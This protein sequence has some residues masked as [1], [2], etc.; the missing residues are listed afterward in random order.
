MRTSLNFPIIPGYTISAQISLSDRTIVYRAIEDVKQRPVIIK[1]L[2][3]TDPSPS[4]VVQFCNQYEILCHLSRAGIVSPVSLQPC[5]HTYALVMEDCGSMSLAEYQRSHPLS[6]AEI[7]DVASQLATA[8]HH[9][10]QH[11]VIHKDLKPANILIHPVTKQVQPIDF[12]IASLLPKETP[13]A[14]APKRLEGTLAY[15]APEQTGRMNRGVDYRTDFYTLGVTLFELLTGT[16][17]FS[18]NDPIESVY[19][20]LAKQPPRVEQLCPELPV[21]LSDLVGKLMAKNPE[22]RYQSA[23]GLKYDLDL[24]LTQWQAMGQIDRFEIATHDLSERFSV[25]AKLYGRER[26]VR[27][28]LAAVDRVANGSTELMLIAGCSG[29]G[30]TAIVNEI[31]QPITR[32]RG[33]FIKG[34]FDQFNRN[35]PL[36]AFVQAFRQLM[37]MLLTST[38]DRLDIWKTQILAALGEHTRVIIDVIP[39]LELIVGSQPPAPEL[40]GSAGQN[41]FNLLFQKFVGVFATPDHPLTIFIDDLQ[42]ADS[43]S[44]NL[45]QLMVSKSSTGNLLTIGAYRDNEVTAA[46]PLMLTIAEASAAGAA[47]ETI[48]LS[49][50][51]DASLHQLVSDTLMC[52][53]KLAQPMTDLVY[54]YTRGNPFFATQL[55]KT[56]H[57]DG[58]IFLDRSARCWQY[59]I[60]QINSTSLTDD[61]VELMTQQLHRLPVSTQTQ[62]QVAA[63]IGDKFD[64]QTLTIVSAQTATT[65][66]IDLLPA[67]QE[68][69][70]LPIGAADKLFQIGTGDLPDLEVDAAPAYKFLHDRVQQAA[71]ALIPAA[72]M[73]A[74]HLQIGRL[75]Q[76]AMALGERDNRVFEI[77]NHLNQGISLIV[78]ATE[79]Q[80]LAQLDLLAGQ[81]AQQAT[82]YGSALDYFTIGIDLL[83]HDCWECQYPLALAIYTGAAESA[84]LC[85]NFELMEQ[86]ARVVLD[87]ADT[88]LD[89]A[90]VYVIKIQACVARS[91]MLAAIELAREFLRNLDIYLP[92][93]STPAEIEQS[94][95]QIQSLFDNIEIESL[96]ELPITISPAQQA[97]MTILSS[98]MSAAFQVAPDLLPLL[99]FAQVDL[100]I[101][102]GN[103][104]ES[105]YGYIMYGLLLVTMLE[106]IESGY[107]FGRVGMTL[108]DRLH[109]PNLAAKTIF[110]FNTHLR[111]LKEPI[112][113]TLTGIL[114]AYTSGLEVGDLEYVA[115]SL[116]CYSYTAYHSGQELDRLRQTFDEHRN[117]LQCFRQNNYLNIQSIY[118]QSVLKLLTPSAEVDCL[119]S[120]DYDETDRIQQCL[121]A[122]QLTELHQIYCSKLMLSYLFQRYDRAV[123]HARLA[124]QYANVAKGLMI[125]QIFCFYDALTQLAIYPA[126]DRLDRAAILERVS[127]HQVQFTEWERH[128]PSNHAH[129]C[130][131]IA[132]ERCRVLGAKAEALD[133]YDRA[134]NLASANQFIHTAAIANELAAKFYLDWD[135]PKVAAGYLQAAY[136]CYFQWGAQAK[137][138]DLEQRYPHL[139]AQSRSC[140]VEFPITDR[141]IDL[142]AKLSQSFSNSTL[143]ADLDLAAILQASQSLSSTIELQDLL[144]QLTQIILHN[145]GGDLCALILPNC[146]GD[147]YLEALATSDTT[148]VRSIPLTDARQLPIKLI[149]YVKHTQ[150]VVVIDNLNTDL[151]IIDE[152]L[153][154]HQ[155]QSML[156]LPM[157]DRGVL[158]GILYLHNR[159]TSRVFTP[160]RLQVLHLLCAQA[161]ISLA[162]ARLYQQSQ[163][164]AQ[165]LAQSLV[166]LR[167]SEARFQKFAD[168]LPGVLFQTR[169]DAKNRS[170]DITYI[171]ARCSEL[172]EIGA[173]A[174]MTEGYDLRTFEHP[175][176]TDRI[177]QS[178]DRAIE[179]LMPIC[180]EFRIVTPSGKVKWVQ[181]AA[182]PEIQ[183][184]GYLTWD[185]VL[186]DISDRKATEL[187]LHQTQSQYLRLGKN[188]P[189]S[190]YQY[191][192][193][194]DGTDRFSYVSPGIRD[195]YG[196]EPEAAMQDPNALWSR[197]WPED[198]A[199]LK[200][201]IAKS[202]QTLESFTVEYRI[203]TM[204]ADLK[205][206]AAYSHP[207][208]RDNGDVV[209]DGLLLDISDR[210]QAELQLQ[211][212]NAELLRANR[213]KDEFLA[214]MSHELRTPLNAILGMSEALKEQVFGPITERQ[215]KALTTI[216]RSGS[217]LLELIN[218]ILDLAKIESGQLELDY[219]PTDINLLCKSSLTFIKQQALVKRIALTT[220]IPPDLPQLLVDERRIRQVLINLLNNAVKF[221]P[222]G[223]QVNL[224][225]SWQQQFNLDVGGA[226]PHNY[227]HIAV[228]DTGLGIAP[229]HIDRLFQ[230]FIQIDSA[231]NRQY[232]GTGLGLAL[233]KKIVELHRGRVGLTSE[234]GVGSC[235]SI[236]LPSAPIELVPIV[237]I[238]P[239]PTESILSAPL[240]IRPHSILIVE[241]NEANISTISSYLAANGYH[242][243]IA[244]NGLAAIELTQ[245][246]RPDLI[247]M[248]IQMP[249]M[250][251]IAAIHA[252][253]SNPE[254]LDISIVA[255]TALAMEGDRER[256]LAAGANEYI[257]KPIKLKQLLTTIQQLLTARS[258]D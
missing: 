90:S 19:C 30:K 84:Y 199:Q 23:L 167:A 1:L 180:E 53:P 226:L 166:A 79:R 105:T 35:I 174:M 213:L 196:C 191:I 27:S 132:A 12:G 234:L 83:E 218:D 135:K 227:I 94:L 194:P 179:H 96:L 141:S 57:Q 101:S 32:Q 148:T 239:A 20:H 237:S 131:L 158:T 124:R 126:A 68:G 170:V 11:Q 145:S 119:S 202:I 17:P 208:R 59:D 74:I 130:L 38:D 110:G 125:F 109:A 67:L 251:G 210:K 247:L 71:Y 91:Q 160:D 39:E 211:Q 117:V 100:S 108:L 186:L 181:V 255:L 228:T 185:G 93:R 80:E 173:A 215:L 10:A 118:Y 154:L 232:E 147:W 104:P 203:T 86:L 95:A 188:I 121:A 153:D 177:A 254:S 64:L 150:T 92:E 34:K 151:P 72:Q 171:S 69:L 142:H 256:C 219:Q 129:H 168:N 66:A 246:A 61:V 51:T 189:G 31:Y 157:L 107:R 128:A 224:A 133:L 58:A 16:L 49:P 103:A 14:L 26:E 85:T 252:I 18:C 182:Q 162:N 5:Q 37:G 113:N 82:A 200:E 2:R 159:S 248:D 244:T 8:L 76:Q 212:T 209:W 111:Y 230:P 33:Y 77:V 238:T 4:E 112:R 78:D 7:L 24:C 165:N 207:E 75:Q 44:L 220:T 245:S 47:I 183:A 229:E 155:P 88:W 164:S 161:A 242:L 225:V 81:K 175:D 152:Y 187:A 28:L 176:D 146:D 223:G 106:E 62:L 46:H 216:E 156:C 257:S 136:E 102:Y 241:D 140:P 192:L 138:E 65:V 201:K 137:I 42:W 87:R 240:T 41:R 45:I 178:R 204:N 233:V 127:S 122:N 52:S 144:H 98:V 9:L 43:A 169:I 214:T 258:V 63:C 50:L 243:T 114:A 55:L 195:L 25:S 253:R 139:L 184:D 217:H 40:S 236:E 143:N 198:L 134:I 120:A 163:T 36:S 116:V 21:V 193:H 3:S 73:P 250:D 221:T 89:R 70:I 235:F 115:L 56:L 22:D 13:E 149:Q 29:I 99:V 6:L 54:R 231:L 249:G 60:T 123:E 222:E 15:L 97:A 172:Y 206:L 48:G 197:T 190:I 205:W